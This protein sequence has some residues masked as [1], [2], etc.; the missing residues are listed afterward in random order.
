MVLE[1]REQ[2]NMVV[3][4]AKDLVLDHIVME[5]QMTTD[6]GTENLAGPFLSGIHSQDN[7]LE[8]MMTAQ[9]CSSG[10]NMHGSNNYF[11]V[12]AFN[13]IKRAAKFQQEKV[14]M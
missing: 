14:G 9:I 4:F 6:D 2:K 10:Y 13:T 3:A 8:P 12:S 7:Q 11:Q 1:A 5:G